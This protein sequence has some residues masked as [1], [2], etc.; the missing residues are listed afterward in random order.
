[1]LF[2]LRVDNSFESA[3]VRWKNVSYQSSPIYLFICWYT[4][5]LF[6]VNLNQCAMLVQIL[7]SSSFFSILIIRIDWI[8]VNK[9]N[10][11]KYIDEIET[12]QDRTKKLC[13][14]NVYSCVQK[15]SIFFSLA[16]RA[17]EIFILYLWQL[18]NSDFC[19]RISAEN[20]SGEL[21][22]TRFSCWKCGEYKRN[23]DGWRIDTYDLIVC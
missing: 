8:V 11:H 10:P 14:C 13:K 3:P 12:R 6:C 22:L 15:H 17:W 19:M 1:M 18:Q 5:C 21:N 7:F 23:R 9:T 16:G 2:F 20:W 4:S